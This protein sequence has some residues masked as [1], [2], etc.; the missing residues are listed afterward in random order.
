MLYDYLKS[1]PKQAT[2]RFVETKVYPVIREIARTYQGMLSVDEASGLY[3]SRFTPVKSQDEYAPPDVPNCFDLLLS[4]EYTFRKAIEISEEL[5]VDPDLR[6]EWNRTIEA[7][8]AYEKLE[9]G[10][11]YLTYEGDDR[12]G[13]SEKHPVQLNPIALL[14]VPHLYSDSRVQ[15]AYRKRY[16]ITLGYDQ[17]KAVAWTLGE[18]FLA[19]V[20]MRDSGGIR[21]DMRR[22]RSTDLVDERFIQV[23][24]SS[25]RKSHFMTTTGFFTEGVT[26]MFLQWWKG[27]LEFFP[28]ILPEWLEAAGE[29]PIRFMNIRAPGGFVVSGWTTQTGGEIEIGCETDGTLTGRLPDLWESAQLRSASGE[30]LKVLSKAHPAF[31]VPVKAG[32]LYRIVRLSENS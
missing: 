19:S 31:E 4:A 24:E 10:D 9:A 11:L 21:E 30:A 26:E 6:A 7:G 15:E 3:E 17:D 18:F 8:L 23:F 16:E 14:P 13:R 25:G 28:A 27:E 2:R 29:E 1:F 22:M 12:G 32:E 20:R 5:E